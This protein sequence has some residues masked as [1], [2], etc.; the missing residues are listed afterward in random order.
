MM[1]LKRVVVTG[2]GAITPIGNTFEEYWQGLKNGVS[3][4]A[5]ITKFDASN[6]RTKFACELKGFNAENFIDRKEIR[7]LDPFALLPMPT[8]IQMAV[9]IKIVWALFG[10]RVLVV[11]ILFKNR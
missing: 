1:H 11:S 8:L 6:F 10:A 7:R 2:L 3:G 5:T 9:L 4:A